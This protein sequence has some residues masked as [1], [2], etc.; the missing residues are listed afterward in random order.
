M[1]GKRKRSD[2][3]AEIEA[4][5]RMEADQL[6]AEGLNPAEAETAAQRAF[7]NR[8]RAEERFY[9]SGRWM[10]WD[11]LVRDLRFAMRMLAKDPLFSILAVL[12]LALGIAVSTTIFT[13]IDASLQA[14]EVRQDA[15]SYVGLTRV[16]N[17]RAQGEFSYAEYEYYRDRATVFRAVTALSGRERF[18]MGQTSGGE[19]EEVQGRFNSANFLWAAA[20]L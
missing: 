6:Q 18:M 17:G 11:H 12:G 16:I 2:F 9:E 20:G 5:L 4:H 19:A 13:L 15:N 3:R 1:W 10:V 8:T 7:G 14:N